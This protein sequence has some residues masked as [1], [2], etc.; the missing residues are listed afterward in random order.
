MV[1]LDHSPVSA[2]NFQLKSDFIELISRKRDFRPVFIDIA[3]L[4]E[5]RTKRF[6][7]PASRHG[8]EIICGASCEIGA[9]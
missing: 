1:K 9:Q 8:L 5:S 7:V 3:E 6:A 2:D 4:E